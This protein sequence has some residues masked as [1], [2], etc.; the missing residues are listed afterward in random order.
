MTKLHD[1]TREIAQRVH[2]LI[3]SQPRS[4]TIDELVY[5]IGSGSALGAGN[6][7]SST[8]PEFDEWQQLAIRTRD[9]FTSGAYRSA[10]NQEASDFADPLGVRMRELE[11]IMFKKP[12]RGMDDITRLAIVALYWNNADPDV[13]LNGGVA[14][15]ED[16]AGLDERSRGHLMRAICTLAQSAGCFPALE[17]VRLGA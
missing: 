1:E 8:W 2:A 3:H 10:S 11:E 5:A 9:Y 16:D 15:L 6:P 17:R 14:G 12:V 13:S 7:A 4:P